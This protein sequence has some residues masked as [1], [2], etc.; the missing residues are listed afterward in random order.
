MFTWHAET[1]DLTYSLRLELD[2]NGERIVKT[3]TAD[4]FLCVV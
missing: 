4:V 1:F 2:N 3:I